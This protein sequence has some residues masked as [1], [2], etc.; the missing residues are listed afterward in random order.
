[1]TERDDIIGTFVARSDENKLND[2]N[3]EACG[4]FADSK[5]SGN[6]SAKTDDILQVRIAYRVEPV[7]NDI[8]GNTEFAL[9]ANIH[10]IANSMEISLT[11]KQRVL[12]LKMQ[13]R[14]H[15]E[16]NIKH[17]VERIIGTEITFTD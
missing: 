6:A 13:L 5:P 14:R 12:R 11:D 3:H 7:K 15:Y 1:M 4:E 10:A 16:I 2:A 17:V 8:C 9:T